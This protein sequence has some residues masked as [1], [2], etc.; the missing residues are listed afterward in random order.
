MRTDYSDLEVDMW[1]KI[2]EPQKLALFCD[3]PT[4]FTK[5]EVVEISGKGTL[6]RPT[7]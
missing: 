2:K 5:V 3:D 6:T 1:L 7:R 4:V